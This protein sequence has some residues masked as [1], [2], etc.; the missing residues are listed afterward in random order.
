MAA[1]KSVT[2]YSVVLCHI[3][4]CRAICNKWKWVS[5]QL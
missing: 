3:N 2:V 4:E 5:E 1:S